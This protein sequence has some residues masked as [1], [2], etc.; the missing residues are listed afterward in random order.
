MLFQESSSSGI[1]ASLVKGNL[2][3]AENWKCATATTLGSFM[4]HL[5][6]VRALY[7]FDFWLLFVNNILSKNGIVLSHEIAIHLNHAMQ[8]KKG[9]IV[10]IFEYQTILI[11]NTVDKDIR[12]RWLPFT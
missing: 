1:N 2:C 10:L 7:V 6:I 3:M 8:C 12:Q 5:K 9:R 4:K 11:V